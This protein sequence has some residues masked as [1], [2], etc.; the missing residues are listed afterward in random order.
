MNDYG[1]LQ[2]IF[3]CATRRKPWHHDNNNKDPEKSSF[4]DS[5]SS[6]NNNNNNTVPN[7]THD[8]AAEQIVNALFTAEIGGSTTL[9]SQ[10]NN[11][12]HQ[13][14]GWSEWLADRIRRG[15]EQALAQGR[16]MSAALATA[17]DKACEAATVFEGFVKEHPIATAVFVTVIAIGVLVVLT[18][19]VVEMLGFGE[20]GPIEGEFS[21]KP[22][23]SS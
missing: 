15:L 8:E 14:G 20:L 22:A 19:Y 5:S 10:L 12:A 9:V 7:L 13:C 16:K 21:Y 1:C 23:I 2:A 11:I 17:Y 6:E 3:P 4:S 18:P